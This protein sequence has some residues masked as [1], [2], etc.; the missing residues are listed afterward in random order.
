MM[1]IMMLIID[2]NNTTTNNNSNNEYN[3]YVETLNVREHCIAV[4]AMSVYYI[5]FFTYT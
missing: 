4:P 5:I 3:F 1:N 2:S